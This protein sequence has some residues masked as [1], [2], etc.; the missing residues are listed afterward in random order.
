[1]GSAAAGAAGVALG[2]DAAAAKPKSSHLSA[3]VVIVGAGLAGMTAA[4][5]LT[6]AGKSVVVLEARD[7]VG[8]RVHNHKISGGEI[9]EKGGTFTGPT[10]DRIQAMAERF[11]VDTFPTFATGDNVYVNSLG[12]R[13]T[14]TDMP[15]FGTAP[16]DPLIVGDLATVVAQ[17]D[18]MATEI[19]V[20]APYDAPQAAAR[21]GQTFESWINDNAV[22]PQFKALV[23][24]A[25]R[26]IF[27]AEPREISLLYV[28]FYIAASGNEQNVGTFE[29]NFNTQGGA[30]ESRFVGG[31]GRITERMA[32][33]LGKRI[34]L[35]APVTRIKQTKAGVTVHGKG[36]S[37][38]AKRVIVAIP[39]ALASRI[40]YKP[41]MPSRR[42]QLT[43]RISQGTLM[44]AT[45]V[46]DE[47]F[48]REDGLNGT[49]VSYEGPVNVTYDASPPDGSPGVIFGFIGGDVA[50]D[51]R[52][53]TPSARKAAVLANFT[54]YYGAEAGSPKDYFESDWPGEQW[55]RGGPVG[56]TSPGALYAYGRSLREPVGR[57][58][59][60]GTETAGYWV[61][62]MDG[63][64]R[65]GE[66]VAAEVLAEL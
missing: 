42:D 34:V 46:Y 52:D 12:Q 51:F 2:A 54:K 56:F 35:K 1:M 27:G 32:K 23:P 17:L 4:L 40:T 60:A 21:D 58:H 28:L 50:R 41:L 20:E 44:K 31:T 5:D 49:V 13:S 48:W 22:T 25:T 53:L 64:V 39:P 3:D 26:P 30:Q 47:P 16:P 57:I 15:P 37:V 66:R 61:G 6:D 55:S 29:R 65:S 63:A 11:N 43:Q 62:Y 8:G 18:Q 45:C 19:D 38:R 7:R 33:A 24:V 36:V 59:W 10:Q 9:S 14:Y